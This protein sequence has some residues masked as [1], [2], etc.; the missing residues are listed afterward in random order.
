MPRS[1]VPFINKDVLALFLTLSLSA[2]LLFTRTSTQIQHLKFQVAKIMSNIAYPLIWYQ[3]VFT[4]REENNLLKE[5]LLQLTL[6]NSELESF[7]QENIRLKNMLDFK[8]N[9]PLSFISAHV[10]NHKFGL[11]A[12]S[13]TIDVGKQSGLVKNLTVMDQNGLI[14]KTIEVGENAALVQLITDKNFRVSIR[15]GKESALGLFIPTHGKYGILEGVRKS[16]LLNEGEIA[17][18]SGISEIY[19]PN[20]P[21]AKVLS[22]NR[23]DDQ[24]FQHVVVE[25]LGSINNFDFVFIIL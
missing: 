14:G 9:Q 24:P 2:S 21:V 10:V 4:I 22:V 3:D 1:R 25:L 6:L 7:R 12:Q 8:E 13:I 23:Y 11:L 20:I 19:P 17:Y 15:V 5:Q 18:T 16:M